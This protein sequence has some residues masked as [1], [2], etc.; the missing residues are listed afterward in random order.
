MERR[1]LP[2]PSSRP[3]GLDLGCLLS[4]LQCIRPVLLGSIG[5]GAVAVEDVVARLDFNSFSEGITVKD[6]VL[7]CLSSCL[8]PG[9]L[10]WE[11][12]IDSVGECD[13]HGLVELLLSNG[14]V[15]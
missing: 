12:R 9:R 8:H 4:I 14:L 3:V 1:A 11:K 2:T 13:L 5:C 7:V 10:V 15:A 6:G